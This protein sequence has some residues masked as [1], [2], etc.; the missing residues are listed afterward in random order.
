MKKNGISILALLMLLASP[1]L[2]FATPSRQEE[3]RKFVVAAATAMGGID[4]LQALKSLQFQ[5]LGHWNMLEQSERPEGPWLVAYDKIQE[6]RDLEKQRIRQIAEGNSPASPQANKT[7]LVVA[8]GVAALDFNGKMGPFTMAQV[9]DAQEWLALG[10]ERVLLTALA[11]KDLR[12]ER[13]TIVQGVPHHVVSFTWLDAPVRLYLNTH[14]SLPTIV[15][16]VRAHPFDTFWSVWGDFTSRTYFS[17]WTLEANGLRYPH[18]WDIERNGQAY[19]TLIINSIAFNGELS[20]DGFSIPDDVKQAFA[21]RGKLAINDVPL[22][23]PNQQ[24]TEIASGIVQIRGRWNVALIKQTDGVVILEA[25]ISSGYSAKVIAEA[26]KRFPGLPVK[27][28]IST[29]DAFPHFAGLR[30]YVARGIPVYL[31]DLNLPIARRLV[32]APFRTYA[33]ALARNPRKATFKI[34][35]AKTEIGSG[36]NRLELYPIRSESGERMLMVYAPQH[37]LLY[38][39]D[40][41]Q[42]MP[43][44][45]FFMPQYLSELTDAAGR[46]KLM[47]EKVFAMHSAPLN[48]SEIKAAIQKTINP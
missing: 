2:A 34:V 5:A 23:L 26:E 24:P 31:L 6:W 15:E 29:S 16:L 4:K 41:V 36:E 33:D 48:W 38:G 9:Q 32:D 7:T 3:A 44:G 47:V 8:D 17:F 1:A 21:I 13:D 37:Q 42:K 12:S 27:A 43:N 25:P 45:S 19:R 28:V 22:G 10:P 11:A 30:E 40:L 35:S 20:A 18:Q 46:E 14:T 39:S